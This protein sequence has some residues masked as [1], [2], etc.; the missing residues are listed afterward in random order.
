L[1]ERLFRV[2][3]DGNAITWYLSN[4]NSFNT[5]ATTS[6][7]NVEEGGC[8]SLFNARI[9]DS[10]IETSDMELIEDELKAGSVVVYPNPATDRFLIN[11]VG[12]QE[13][14]I[15]IALFDSQGKYHEVNTYWNSSPN[16]V[17][18][19]VSELNLGIYILKVNVDGNENVLR[20]I[21]E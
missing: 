19:D 6:S 10:A 3:F 11:V 17:E 4:S 12:D 18:L 21:K 1:E 15:N 5:T 13:S 7:A 16:T 2:P 8:N 20:F 14:D 9:A